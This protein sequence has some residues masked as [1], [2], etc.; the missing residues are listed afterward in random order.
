MKKRVVTFGEILMRLTTNNY[1]R[2]VQ[3]NEFEVHYGGTEANVAVA[4]SNWGVDTSH[5][6][7]LPDND[8]GKA[9]TN[10]L[11]QYGVNTNDINFAEGRMGIYFLES[12]AMQR[13]SKIVYDRFD[14]AFANY[15]FKSVDWD[16]ILDGVD[17]LHWT[18]ITAAI[19][20][21]AAQMCLDALT[22]AQQKGITIS[23]DINYRRNLWQYGKTPLEIMPNLI[24]KTNVIV[25]GL[26]DFENCLN[27]NEKEYLKTC[28]AVAAKYPSV[29]SITTTH[30]TTI[31]SSHNKL[32]GILWDKGTV[33]ESS[34]YDMTHIVDRI[35][36]GD[37]YMAGL[38]YGMLHLD[39]ENALE[40]AVAS[41]V[42]KH[43]VPG[44]AN[45]VSLNEVEQL[46][47]GKNVGKL[48]R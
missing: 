46:A 7:A 12:G 38:I 4:L 11:R 24:A 42:L 9:A 2:F 37:A 18:G 48:L 47:E 26:I 41:S 5:I 13:P 36:G 25:S 3:A 32:S 44:D 21:N 39:L 17:W 31:N 22:V 30:R 23:G 40:F 45:L 15:D 27:I 20:K 33:Y 34:T 6:G 16:R 14:S 1:K 10:Y 8:L 43:S 28:E 29:T 35:G 19:S